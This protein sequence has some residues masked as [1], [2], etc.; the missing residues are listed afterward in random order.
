MTSTRVAVRIAIGASCMLLGA[1]AVGRAQSPGL[2]ASTN[3]APATPQKK[4]LPPGAV[5]Q[6]PAL[7]AKVAPPQR[8]PNQTPSRVTITQDGSIEQRQ[9]DGSIRRSRPGVCGWTII[10]P[11]GKATQFQCSTN[12]QKLDLPV[13]SGETAVW[14]EAHANSL[15]DIARSLLGPNAETIGNHLSANEAELPGVYDRILIRTALVSD[16]ARAVAG[17]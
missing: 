10:A 3:Q 15:L 4:R 2:S 12:V 14:L 9:A 17:R 11:N 16:L 7:P 1:V 8:D 5:S 6:V 13:P